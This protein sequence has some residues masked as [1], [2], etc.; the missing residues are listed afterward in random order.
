MNLLGF[1]RPP[2]FSVY[3]VWSS[4]LIHCVLIGFRHVILKRGREWQSLWEELPLALHIVGS[5]QCIEAFDGLFHYGVLKEWQAKSS[6]VTPCLEWQPWHLC[7]EL[8]R[9]D[10]GEVVILHLSILIESISRIGKGSLF[11]SLVLPS[12]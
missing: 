12:R 4:Q 6:M 3:V 11:I 7:D 1:C 5:G 9:D 10:L 2:H 8:L